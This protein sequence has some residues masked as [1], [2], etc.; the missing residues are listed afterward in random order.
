MKIYKALILAALLGSG[1]SSFLDEEPIS[2]ITQENYYKTEQDAIAAVNALYDYISVGNSGLWSGE[3][4]GVYYNDYWITQGLCSDEMKTASAP[5][6]YYYQL[7]TFSFNSSNSGLEK[8]WKDC[9][10]T[11]N[12]ANLAIENIP[13]IQMDEE[14]KGKLLGEAKFF[15]AMLYF[16]LVRMY[17]DVPLRTSPTKG[18]NDVQGSR[19]PSSEV[20]AQIEND[21][22]DAISQ[23]PAKGSA[24]LGR[25][26]SGAAKALLAKVYLTEGK[27]AE[28]AT[29]CKELID[30]GKYQLFSDFKDL[31]KISNANREEIIFSIPFSNTLSQGWK[32]SQFN[33][34]L[35][36]SGLNK[37][38]EGPE[39]AQGW[40]K[41]TMDLYNSFDNSD[42]R[43][44]VSFITS[45]KYSDGSSV[46]FEPHIAKW[47]DMEAEPRANQSD[48][49]YIYLRYA[50][51]LLMYAEALNEANGGPTAEAYEAINQVRTRARFDGV[52]VLNILPDL[53]GLGY[54]D[55]KEAILEERRH[56]FVAEGHRWFDLV[57]NGKLME[58]V[59]LATDKTESQVADFHNLFP[60]PQRDRELNSSLTQNPGY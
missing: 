7:S 48:Q 15:R 52:N 36:P 38:G 45:Y 30:S 9:Y 54:E 35:L 18:V 1:C 13:P 14:L 28:S 23:L 17:G 8:V 42:R 33:V 47:W 3:F 37:A 34:Q 29:I 43:K 31:F 11:I 58:K 41:P 27:Y 6:S 50:D 56:E 44:D 20:Y 22:M 59:K 16:D 26:T 53:S 40:Q 19:T 46:S 25:C 12:T 10:K 2:E 57:R 32:G 60:I 5:G 21:L 51:V 4:G 49:D 24:D 39:N 55:F